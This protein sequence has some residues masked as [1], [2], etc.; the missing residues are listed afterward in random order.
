MSSAERV[1]P[2]PNHRFEVDVDRDGIPVTGFSDVRGLAVSVKSGT[3]AGE[4]RGWVDILE[5][6]A[7]GSGRQA[8]ATVSGQRPT[9][10]P[11][12]ELRRGV[13]DDT[14]LWDW[15]QRWIDGTADPAD[16][17]VTL[18]D[19]TGA[20]ARTWVCKRARPV[21]WRGPTLTATE[22]GVAT[23]RYELAH[24]GVALADVE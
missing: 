20:R 17:R 2:Y 15:F 16:V 5:R 24:N 21:R 4:S 8:D 13:T 18:L 10:S 7:R 12:L 1:D 23:E 6:D 14:S 9:E 22:P 3:P 11:R 19:S